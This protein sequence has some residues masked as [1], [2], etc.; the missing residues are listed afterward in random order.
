[1]L[2]APAF[3]Y[4][5]DSPGHGINDVEWWDERGHHLSPEDW[6]N[7][8]ARALVM[9]RATRNEAGE[10]EA[11]S[12]LLN[13]GTDPLTFHLPPPGNK[14]MVLIDSAKPDQGE[15]EIGDEY[16]VAPQGAVLLTWTS[17]FES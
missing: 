15:L 2:R 16:E 17:A 9:R 7:P 10:V 4:G 14:R 3:L 5:Q 6:Q 11:M 1:M 13:A 8:E 12:L